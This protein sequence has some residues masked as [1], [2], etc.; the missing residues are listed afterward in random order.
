MMDMTLTA[1]TNGS[2]CSGKR[3]YQNRE[4]RPTRRCICV[5][6]SVLG[7][8]CVAPDFFGAIVG[9]TY[10]DRLQPRCIGAGGVFPTF[11]NLP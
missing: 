3:P 6:D 2:G 5:L 4:I 9:E 11:V 8:P 7:S 1:S 10:L